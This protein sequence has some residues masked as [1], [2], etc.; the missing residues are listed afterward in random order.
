MALA[1][2]LK[3]EHERLC[4]RCASGEN[5]G[6]GIEQR[7][8][9]ERSRNG[10]RSAQSEQGQRTKADACT[11]EPKAA[12]QQRRENPCD[13]NVF[14]HSSALRKPLI[15]DE[16]AEWLNDYILSHPGEERTSLVR[17]SVGQFLAAEAAAYEEGR[18]AACTG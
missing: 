17:R 5:C 14:Y 10:V 6:K 1:S 3:I 9:L 8:P 15:A 11:R 12:G 7:L 16:R 4:R 13:L 2:K 18:R